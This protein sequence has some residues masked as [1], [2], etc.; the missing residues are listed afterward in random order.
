MFD[1]L[2]GKKDTGS[3]P[4]ASVLAEWNKYSGSDNDVEAGKGSG[5]SGYAE[6]A[7]QSL[8]G[9]INTSFNTVSTG[10]NQV[11]SSISSSTQQTSS[12]MPNSRQFVYFGFLMGGGLL[13]LTLAFTVALPMLVL[14]PSKFA[15]SFSLGCLCM[16]L[17]F[18]ALRGWKQSFNHMTSKERLPFTA[19][20]IASVLG[21]LYAAMM[22]HSY[23]LSLFCSG[24]QVIAL[25]YYI[26]SYFPG[27]AQG[28]QFVLGMFY[29]GLVG[30]VMSAKSVV[31]RS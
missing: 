7:G 18:S 6:Q 12:L 8:K 29:Q 13:F 22:M 1:A 20:Y 31:F 19:G 14:S 9:F 24:I 2:F 16:L 25:I 3:E 17:A 15:I 23:L 21:T 10:V 4:P 28:V 27:G 11:S 26:V 5:V 30:C